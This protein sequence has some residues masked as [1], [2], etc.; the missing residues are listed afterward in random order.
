LA[1]GALA[2]AALAGGPVA[3][4]AIVVAAQPAVDATVPPGT[5]P[6]ELNTRI[7]HAR[8]RLLLIGPDGKSVV[9]PLDD[10]TPPDRLAAKADALAPGLYR[11]RTEV[12]RFSNIRELLLIEITHV[13]LA[14]AGITAGRAR[15]LELRMDGR[16]ALTAAWVWPAAFVPVGSTLLLYREA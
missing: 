9:L 14:L 13:P 6:I 4:H 16:A 7:D 1:C 11:L 2:C 15:W 8:S 10:D 3:A 12:L 5:V